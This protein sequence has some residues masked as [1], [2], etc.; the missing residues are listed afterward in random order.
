MYLTDKQTN[1]TH[2]PTMKPEHY[3]PLMKMQ[4]DMRKMFAHQVNEKT[5][6]CSGAET[7]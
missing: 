6:G 7:N 5:V 3:E 2:K 1:H 4:V